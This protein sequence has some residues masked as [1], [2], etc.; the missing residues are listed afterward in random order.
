[1]RFFF[2]GSHAPRCA[3]DEGVPREEATVSTTRTNISD[4]STRIDAVLDLI[5]RTLAECDTAPASNA[6]AERFAA[7]LDELGLR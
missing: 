4:P 1:M 7:L 6:T 2:S 5:D 3:P